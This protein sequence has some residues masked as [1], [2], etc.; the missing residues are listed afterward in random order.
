MAS[1]RTAQN[2]EKTATRGTAQKRPNY[3]WAQ[4]TCQTCWNGLKLKTG[5]PTANSDG[6]VICCFCNRDVAEGD[7]VF[8]LRTNP[9][10]VPYPSVVK[11][12]DEDEDG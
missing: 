11:D 6:A 10:V 8:L 9:G 7:R 4:P 1:S 3:S 2:D 12:E 5:R